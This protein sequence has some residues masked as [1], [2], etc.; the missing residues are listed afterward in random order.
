MVLFDSLTCTFLC[1]HFI[2]F[3]MKFY[4]SKIST[5]CTY[6]TKDKTA[7]FL[8]LWS[9]SLVARPVTNRPLL[10][11]CPRGFIVLPLTLS[12]TPAQSILAHCL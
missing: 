2:Q 12:M 7:S 1:T 11:Q 4:A 10:K 6:S 3:L 9:T 8:V 5:G